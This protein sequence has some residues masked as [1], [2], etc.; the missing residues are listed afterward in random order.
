MEAE[1]YFLENILLCHLNFINNFSK[2]YRRK[3]YNYCRLRNLSS[4]EN[5]IHRICNKKKP[6]FGYSIE[7]YVLANYIV[8]FLLLC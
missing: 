1:E 8:L 6:F 7:I 3:L 4:Y 2:M 5:K